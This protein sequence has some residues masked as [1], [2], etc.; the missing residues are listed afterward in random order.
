[1][2]DKIRLVDAANVL[3]PAYL[4]LIQQGYAVRRKADDQTS[5]ETWIAEKDGVELVADDTLALLGLAALSDA[6]AEQWN[7]SDDEIEA[8]LKKFP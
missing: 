3:I 4:T 8:F 5:S 1:M 6:R 2:S 7:A